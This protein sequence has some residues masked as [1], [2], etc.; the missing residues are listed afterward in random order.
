[1]STTCSSTFGPARLPSFVTWP[2]SGRDVLILRG[3]QEL[4][5]RFA[6]LA[7]A[8]RGRLK[9]VGPDG[10]H[11]IDDDKRR[12]QPRD[13]FEDALDAGFGQEIERRIADAKPIATALHLVLGLFSRCIE[14]DQP[15]ERNATR[16]AAATWTCRCPALLRAG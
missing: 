3:K 11:R 6:N 9:L 13:F 8:A 16:P 2:T 5:R 4:R 7:D 1:M 10:L 15:R 12:R 14:P